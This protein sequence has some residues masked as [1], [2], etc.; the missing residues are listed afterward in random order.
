MEDKKITRKQ[1]KIRVVFDFDINSCQRI[2]IIEDFLL[3]CFER[4]YSA[5]SSLVLVKYK[6]YLEKKYTSI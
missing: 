3:W 4:E 2:K 5:D 1:Q 6:K